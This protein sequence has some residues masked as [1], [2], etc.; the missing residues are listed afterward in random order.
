MQ[1]LS[2]APVA[3]VGNRLRI[4][5]GALPDFMSPG[6]D[7]NPASEKIN[8]SR[9]SLRSTGLRLIKRVDAPNEIHEVEL[10][11]LPKIYRAPSTGKYE[12]MVGHGRAH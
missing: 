4:T 7:I 3:G 12:Y 1:S 6:L 5:F 8:F 2:A 11:N 10:T 9:P